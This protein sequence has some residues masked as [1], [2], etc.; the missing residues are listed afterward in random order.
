MRGAVQARCASAEAAGA[1]SRSKSAKRR[2]VPAGLTAAQSAARRA[3]ALL[4]LLT[5]V[6]GLAACRDKYQ[7]RQ[8]LTITIAT[9]SGSRSGSSVV[10]MTALLGQLPASGNEVSYDLSGEA[11]VVELASGK[12]VFALLDNAEERVARAFAKSL[13]QGREDWLPQISGLRGERAVSRDSYPT[14]VAFRSI[15]DPR[16]IQL[17]DPA[18]LARSLGEGHSLA[19]VMVEVVAEEPTRGKVAGILDWL[20]WSTDR[21]TKLSGDGSEPMKVGVPGGAVRSIPR[22]EFISRT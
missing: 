4:L 1:F 15:D 17:L 9:P 6:P 8:K 2:P 19:S 16:S 20:N 14:L 11:T 13:P 21:W 7:W 10:A 3:F 18:D 5:V 12:Y 22:N